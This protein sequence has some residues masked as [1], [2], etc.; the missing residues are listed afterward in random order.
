MLVTCIEV[1]KVRF[2]C[3]L[4]LSNEFEGRRATERALKQ[5]SLESV[6]V[7]CEQRVSSPS[8]FNPGNS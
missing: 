1:R 6:A 8:W 5:S 7:R 3:V 4:N 2:S